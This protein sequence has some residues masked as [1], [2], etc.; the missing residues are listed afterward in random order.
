MTA[1]LAAWP[2]RALG[3]AGL[4]VGPL[5]FGA[6]PMANLGRAVPEK[7][8]GGAVEAAW[9]MGVRYFDVAPHYGLGLGE[10]RLGAG[11]AGHPREELIVS[12]KVGRILVPVEAPDGVLDDEGFAVPAT[13]VRVRDYS[14]DGIRR[15]LEAS[16]ERLG[17]DRVDILFV[18]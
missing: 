8:S 16:L 15:S 18:H 17:L 2:T 5:G 13:H 9:Q 11:L 6:A 12:T 4:R 1:G 7:E 14:S 10:R 3:R